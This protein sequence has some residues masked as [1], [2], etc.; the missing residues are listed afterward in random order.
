MLEF[1][2]NYRAQDRN[3]MMRQAEGATGFKLRLTSSGTLNKQ[4]LSAFLDAAKLSTHYKQHESRYQFKLKSD[5]QGHYL[6][7]KEQGLWSRLKGL[8][9][10][11]R[12]ERETQRMQAAQFIMA[13]S[14]SMDMPIG[15]ISGSLRH[16]MLDG[17][18]SGATRMTFEQ[19][20]IHRA[21]LF[22]R[23]VDKST[24]AG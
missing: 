13:N 8:V 7:L 22:N 19:A 18:A 11:G 4:S 15:E 6:T 21:E 10:W 3:R 5:N 14:R 16:S 23:L 20:K 2:N 12:Q 24:L 9:G 17:V 1:N